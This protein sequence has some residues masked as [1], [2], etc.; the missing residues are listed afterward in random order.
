M[1]SHRHLFVWQR[2]NTQA[3]Q[4]HRFCDAAWRPARAAA[5]EQLRRASLSVML[6]IA[7]GHAYGPGRRCKYHARVAYGS[8]VETTAV[9]EFLESLGCDAPDLRAGSKEV[10][11][12]VMRWMQSVG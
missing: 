6:N 10:Q 2:A 8:S 9:L 12:L 11:A 7:E 1:R 4:V 3:L 5:I